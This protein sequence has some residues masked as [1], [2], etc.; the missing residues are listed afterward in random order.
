MKWNMK[1]KRFIDLLMM[2][3]IW[4]GTGF[5]AGQWEVFSTMIIPMVTLNGTYIVG[6][7]WRPSQ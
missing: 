3:L 7:S 2:N 1:S 6:E 5:V 4:V